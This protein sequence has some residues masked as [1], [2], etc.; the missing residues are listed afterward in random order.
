M[1]GL[2][3]IDDLLIDD[4]YKGIPGGIPPFRLAEMG[5]RGWN[6]LR[7]D[8]PLPLAVLKESALAHNSQWMQKFLALSGAKFAPHGKTTMAP[9]LFRRQLDDGAWG[10]TLATMQQVQVARRFGMSRILLAN[11][12]V[13][14]RAIDFVVEELARDKQFEFLCLVDSAAGVELLAAAV[15]RQSLSRPFEVL[16]E[17]GLSGGR[18][19]CRSMEEALQVARAVHR[20]APY[21][22]LR[23][24]EGFEGIIA[25][26][27]PAESSAKVREFL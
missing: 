25:E 14:P 18:A 24:V 27:T 20:N 23:G 5:S 21:L 3:A 7:G 9:Q 13:D 17:A 10:I 8:L 19:G 1:S 26:P 22:A 12:V 6:V 4:R 15:K 2:A 11:E 16:L